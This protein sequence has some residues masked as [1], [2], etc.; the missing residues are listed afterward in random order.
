MLVL[1][2]GS[3]ARTRKYL[4]DLPITRE[5]DLVCVERGASNDDLLAAA[6]DADAIVAD[7]ISPVDVRLIEAMPN[8]KLIHSEGVA[9]NAIDVEAARARGIAVCNCAGVNAGTVAEQAV[10]LMLMCLRRALEGDRAVREGRQ[11]A[12]KERMMVEG[13]RELGDC[14][15]GFVGFGAIGQATARYLRPWGCKMLY[16][17]RHPLDEGLEN[18]LGVHFASLD[19]LLATCDIVS[20]HVPVT[21][22]TRGMVDGAFLAKMRSDGV[23]INTARGDIVD[24]EALVA[25]LE[26]GSIAAAGLDTLTPEPVTLD[27][28]LVNLSTEAAARVSSRPM[29]AASRRACSIGRTERF[30]KTSLGL[31]R[32]KNSSIACASGTRDSPLVFSGKL[33]SAAGGCTR[34]RA[35]AALGAPCRCR[36]RSIPSTRFRARRAPSR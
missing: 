2:V 16:N 27:N 24:Q 7:A 19:D 32:G 13:F 35:K 21:D 14:T 5:V 31:Q 25:A 4:P 36:F 6:P 20:L 11:I 28:P 3:E 10:M 33:R 30:G 22:E 9:F 26:E 8:L 17:K 12:L 29:W 34:F 15:V 23:L 1:T 18:E